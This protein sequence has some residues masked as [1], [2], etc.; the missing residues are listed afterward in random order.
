[1]LSLSSLL[2][3]TFSSPSSQCW[4]QQPASISILQLRLIHDQLECMLL[5][6]PMLRLVSVVSL[7]LVWLQLMLQ[8]LKTGVLCLIRQQTEAQTV[9]LR[10]QQPQR[11]C[12]QTRTEA[13]TSAGLGPLTHNRWAILQSEQR[14]GLL[15]HRSCLRQLQKR[16][17]WLT[18]AAKLIHQMQL[19][20]EGL[21]SLQEILLEQI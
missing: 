11:P 16:I 4:A 15:V 9:R 19:S 1:M 21:I 8:L 20:P 12:W 10:Q 6:T 17:L 13:Q 7:E 14:C 2:A 5:T 3:P 18:L